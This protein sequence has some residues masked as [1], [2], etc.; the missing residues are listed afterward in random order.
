MDATVSARRKA[1]WKAFACGIDN[2][3]SRLYEVND[4]PVI[5]SRFPEWFDS[6]TDLTAVAEEIRSLLRCSNYINDST[7]IIE[8]SASSSNKENM[9]PPHSSFLT[10]HCLLPQAISID[11][12]DAIENVDT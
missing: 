10:R 7:G 2:E 8:N 12:R 11:P 5:A 1:G 4:L 3:E 6:P 9:A